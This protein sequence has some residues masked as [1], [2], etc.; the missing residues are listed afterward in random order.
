MSQKIIAAFSIILVALVMSV[1]SLP[2]VPAVPADAKV[3]AKR[4]HVP[5]AKPPRI[6]K[7]NPHANGKP[8]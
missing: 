5:D 1:A 4:D 6:V 7:R 2:A 8:F 3:I